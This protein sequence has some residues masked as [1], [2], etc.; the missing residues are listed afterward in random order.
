MV[1]DAN[2]V[3]NIVKFVHDMQDRRTT[4]SDASVHAEISLKAV[5]VVMTLRGDWHTELNMAQTIF[6]YGYAG[7]LE[8]FQAMLGWKRINKDVSSSYYQSTQ[9]ITFVF[10]ELT[11]FFVHQFVAQI[12]TATFNPNAETPQQVTQS[13]IAFGVWMNSLKDSLDKWISSCAIFW[14]MAHELLEFIN[15]YRVGNVIVVETNTWCDS[16][17]LNWRRKIFGQ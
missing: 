6:T 14:G 16:A 12:S 13:A 9:L 15:A 10:E 8:E 3:E 4:F 7:F 2:T 5:S 1:G 17:A 11:R